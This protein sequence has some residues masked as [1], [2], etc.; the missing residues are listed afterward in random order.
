[1]KSVLFKILARYC[2]RIRYQKNIYGDEIF[3]TTGKVKNKVKSSPH[4]VSFTEI[5]LSPPGF[6]R[7][8]KKRHIAP[9][10]R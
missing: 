2:N 8:N 6:L 9:L 1:M 10:V 7:H 4:F 3:L 5:Y